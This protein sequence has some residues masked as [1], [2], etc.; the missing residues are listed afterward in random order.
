MDFA[1]DG[2]VE[3]RCQLKHELRDLGIIWLDPTCKPTKDAVEDLESRQLRVREKEAGRFDTVAAM[4]SN[5]RKIDLRL[6][7]LADFLVVHLDLDVYSV[8]TY[9]ELFEAD[10]QSKPIIIHMQ[11]GKTHLPDWLFTTVPHQ[12]VFSTWSEL[13]AYLRHIAHDPAVETFNRWK[14]FDYGRLYGMTEITLT[15]GQIA[16][17]SPEDYYYLR[18]W[19]WCAISQ[20]RKWR[21]MRKVVVGGRNVTRFMHCEVAARM[22]IANSS[23]IDH[24]DGDPLNNIRDNLR[25]ATVSQNLHNRG[26]QSNNHTT[27]VKG[28]WRDKRGGYHAEIG[29]R[30]KKHYLGRFPTL[31]EARNARNE[32]G[33]RLVGP[34]YKRS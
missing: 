7:D 16:R 17:V 23:T 3:W 34:H 10:R 29:V 25:P 2:G 9:N 27:G 30:G 20:K 24:I 28:V 18:R 31:D 22:G 11:Q 5:I 12:M 19:E 4:M 33:L 13:H 32:A 26:P 15:K 6:V 1:R 21:A 14:F 8:G